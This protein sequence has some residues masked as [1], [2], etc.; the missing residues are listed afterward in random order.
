VKHKTYKVTGTVTEGGSPAAGVAV[1]L[2]RGSS[3]GKLARVAGATTG[4]G[5]TFSFAG[6]LGKKPYYFQ[7]KSAAS[8]RSTQCVA[9]LPAT[10]APAGCA[11]AT[12]SQWTAAST[13]VRLKP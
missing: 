3:S 4:S 9:P 7:V 8:E 11:G 13:T 12:L 10:V 2:Y 1:T 5:G 6:K